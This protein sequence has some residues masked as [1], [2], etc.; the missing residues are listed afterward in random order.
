MPKSRLEL[1]ELP[2]LVGQLV[3][4]LGLVLAKQQGLQ[5]L[6]AL[7]QLQVLHFQEQ[8]VEE[9]GLVPPLEQQQVAVG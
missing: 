9:Q 2:K 5:E 6:L 4:V 1:A 7:V 8:L 3:L